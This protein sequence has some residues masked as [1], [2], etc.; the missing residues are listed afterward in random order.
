[1]K[2][3]DT[4]TLSTGEAYKVGPLMI[5]DNWE[6]MRNGVLVDDIIRTEDGQTSTTSLILEDDPNRDDPNH[7]KIKE[8]IERGFIVPEG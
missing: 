7:L 6:L 2:T 5:L 8:S 1:M 4:V 3:G